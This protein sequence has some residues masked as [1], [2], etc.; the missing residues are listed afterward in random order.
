MQLPADRLSLS[1]HCP[2][3]LII[4]DASSSYWLQLC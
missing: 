1:S 4:L 3:Q 2:S